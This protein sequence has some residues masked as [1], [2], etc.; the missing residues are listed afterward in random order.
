M[1]K[2]KFV[3]SPSGGKL[4]VDHSKNNKSGHLGHALVEYEP[5]KLLAFYP[6]CST[7]DPFWNGHSGHGWMKYRRSL[8]GGVS[9]MEENNEENSKKFYDEHGGTRSLMC[10]KAVATDF[11]RIILFYL[12]C[13]MQINGY[14]WEPYYNPFYAIS[15]NEGETF[16]NLKTFADSPGRIWD[17]VCYKGNVYVL[18]QQSDAL[19]EFNNSAY[20]LYVSNDNGNSF[21]IRSQIPFGYNRG[22]FYGS[23][24]FTPEGKLIVYAYD[25][26]DE[27]NAKYIVSED[28]GNTWGINRRSFFA[29]CIRNPQITYFNQRYI[30]H[31]RSGMQSGHFIIYS[32][33]DAIHWDEGEYLLKR[34]AGTGAYS[35][36]V[37]VH[38]KDGTE[39]LLIQTSHAYEKDKTNVIHFFLDKK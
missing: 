7:D 37:I 18:F 14:I 4:F 10:E 30:L 24:V 9:W 39:R 8:D 35:N 34:V 36:N 1:L 6:E 27:H 19:N 20:Y 21:S 32:S 38:L 13:D 33:K 23:M 28:F 29:N 22:V 5:S 3:I 12:Q 31:G 15:D 25:L 2:D 17:A 11:G 26:Y 16:S